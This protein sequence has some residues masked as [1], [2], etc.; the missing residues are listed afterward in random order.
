MAATNP[1]PAELTSFTSTLRFF[2]MAACCFRLNKLTAVK[3]RVE[4]RAHNKFRGVFALPVYTTS[5]A[6]STK[7]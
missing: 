7:E 6:A 2:T 3:K 1:V 4:G 5:T